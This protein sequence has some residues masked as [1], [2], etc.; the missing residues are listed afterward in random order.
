LNTII[1]N[2]K[3]NSFSPFSV[4]FSQFTQFRTVQ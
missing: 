4:F 2:L 3:K 1:L